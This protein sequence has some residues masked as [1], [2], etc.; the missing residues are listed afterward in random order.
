MLDISMIQKRTYLKKGVGKNSF[1]SKLH[2]ILSN[3]SIK[4]VICWSDEGDRFNIFD[5]VKLQ[6]EVIPLYFKHRNMK[7][8]I[9]QLNLH[10]F[11]KIRMGGGSKG[12]EATY[13]TY[14]HTLFRR[15]QPDL[16]QLIKRKASKPVDTDER[17]EQI[18]NLLEK[19]RMLEEKCSQA[20][21]IKGTEYFNSMIGGHLTKDIKKLCLAFQLYTEMQKLGPDGKIP[22]HKMHAYL[23]TREFINSLKS[24]KECYEAKKRHE[25]PTS[26]TP[27]QPMVQQLQQPQNPCQVEVP[28]PVRSYQRQGFTFPPQQSLWTRHS[29]QASKDALSQSKGSSA[30]YRHLPLTSSESDTYMSDGEECEDKD[31]YYEDDDESGHEEIEEDGIHDQTQQSELKTMKPDSSDANLGKRILAP[32]SS[33]LT[34]S[35]MLMKKLNSN[36]KRSERSISSSELFWTQYFNPNSEPQAKQVQKDTSPKRLAAFTQPSHPFFPP[37]ALSANAVTEPSKVHFSNAFTRPENTAEQSQ[38]PKPVSAPIN[39]KQKKSK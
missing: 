6:E 36:N 22:P 29:S 31:E 26:E 35:Q 7:S 4:D 14:R 10:G 11:K 8:F 27:I 32:A 18:N 33:P 9:R 37:R 28:I 3:E 21:N 25:Q 13:D 34:N 19:K 30:F 23:L 2:S 38:L 15:T 12:T 5:C 20:Q 16:L 1:L 24:V 39:Q 17:V